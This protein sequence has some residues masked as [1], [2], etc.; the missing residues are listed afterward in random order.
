MDSTT[1]SPP[2]A[3]LFRCGCGTSL[4][5]KAEFKAHSSLKHNG[6]YVQG[7]SHYLCKFTEVVLPAL[8][9]PKATRKTEKLKE[10]AN[11]TKKEN[12][13]KRGRPRLSQDP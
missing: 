13:N 2:P 12:S 4:P 1:S 11:A 10:K 3:P 8:Q 9:C 5:S 7:G 6:E